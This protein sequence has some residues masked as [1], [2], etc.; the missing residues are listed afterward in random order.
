MEPQ[1]A[2]STSENWTPFFA[3]VAI[4]A[5]KSS[6]RKVEL[7]AVVPFRR[8]EGGFGGRQGENQP[9]MARIHGLEVENIPEECAIG[10]GV[11]AVHDYVSAR[12]HRHLLRAVGTRGR[13]A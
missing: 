3:R 7:M 5:F 1:R 2:S 8:V 9:A 13:S 10:V 12:D 11:S 6:H 4:S